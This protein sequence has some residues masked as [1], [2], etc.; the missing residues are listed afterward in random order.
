MIMAKTRVTRPTI[1][2]F[3][4]HDLSA[5]SIT[6]EAE[7]RRVIRNIL[8]NIVLK[9]YDNISFPYDEDSVVQEYFS[10]NKLFPWRELH[11]KF[12][13]IKLGKLFN[14]L[15]PEEIKRVVEKVAELNPGYHPPNFLSCVSIEYPEPAYGKELLSMLVKSELVEYAY[16]ESDGGPTSRTITANP[17]IKE[18]GYLNRAPE[19]INAKYAWKQNG[20]RG[21][22]T[23]QFIDIEQGW[24]LD[25]KD[26]PKN[27]PLLYGINSEFIAHGTAVLG[28]I[29]MQDNREG[30]IGI[31][32]K[33]R[34]QVISQIVER[35][36]SNGRVRKANVVNDAILKAIDQLNFG[37][38]LLIEAQV[39]DGDLI[40]PVE[41]KRM[42]FDL[43]ELATRKGI[44]VIEPAGNGDASAD[45]DGNNLDDFKDALE[46]EILK[47]T[48]A[49]SHFKDSGAIMVAAASNRN[50]HSKVKSTNFGKRID[51]FA[52]G[53]NVFTTNDPAES[54]DPD[55]P[56][57]PNFNSTSSAAAIIAGAAIIVQSIVEASGEPRLSPTQM[58]EILSENGTASAKIGV[59]P[60]LKKI[61]DHVI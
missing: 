50:G 15:R 17:D 53:T 8:P 48:P 56:Y 49:N 34:P 28:I 42:T 21:E 16:I 41:T 55:R 51:C 23:V 24:A 5:A 40:W 60:D 59:M 26:L 13:G 46:N 44:I 57:L 9:C 54:P 29:F 20:G 4:Q 36:D 58:R 39:S 18:Q 31:A 3:K 14:S 47:R 19:G 61:I 33:A 27:I 37:D 30:G 25:H 38:I 12:P 2:V 6:K 7:K 35:T 43:I 11:E 52:W 10:K 45:P 32:Y 1:K 22:G